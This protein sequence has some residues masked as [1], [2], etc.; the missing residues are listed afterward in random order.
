MCRPCWAVL[1]W[2]PHLASLRLF[3]SD[4][5]HRDID[6]LEDRSLFFFPACVAFRLPDPSSYRASPEPGLLS[7]PERP[8]G[9]AKICAWPVCCLVQ[10]TTPSGPPTS[11][12][13]PKPAANMD[14]LL[15]IGIHPSS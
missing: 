10:A 12:R 5:P 3:T 8:R 15:L 11:L 14:N 7:A 6:P 4:T 2:C 13:D 9:L 1:S